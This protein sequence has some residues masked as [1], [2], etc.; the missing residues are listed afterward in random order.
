MKDER[1]RSGDRRRNYFHQY[2]VNL[3]KS[4]LWRRKCN[5]GIQARKEESRMRNTIELCDVKQ[6]ENPYKPGT[7][8]AYKEDLESVYM[9]TT[10]GYTKL[11]DGYARQEFQGMDLQR[12]F[13]NY[14][15][16]YCVTIKRDRSG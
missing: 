8:W 13:K 1:V 3:R 10:I 9:I 11:S 16:V 14:T 7:M 2:T 15:Q 12:I 6:G 5:H 4:P